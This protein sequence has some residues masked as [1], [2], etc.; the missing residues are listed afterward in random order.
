M[1]Q[2]QA[3]SRIGTVLQDRYIIEGVLGKGG[4]STVYLVRDQQTSAKLDTPDTPDAPNTPN[5]S[6]MLEKQDAPQHDLFALKML[7]NQE[8]QE[9]NRFMFECTVLER[10][11]HPALPHVHG[12]FEDDHAYLLMDYI[13]GPNLETLRQRQ[14]TKRFSFA[15]VLTLLTPIVEA[16]TY[17]H[18]QQPPI[19]HRDIKP[20]NI[21]VPQLMDKAV[22][23]D[24][25]IAKEFEPDATT[26][27]IRHCSPGYGAP[28]QY[29]SMGT[30]QR[31]D[32]YGLAATCY[33]LLTGRVP[34]DALQR[35]TSLAS[36]GVDP[37]L[38]LKELAPTLPANAADAIQRAMSIGSDDRFATVQEFWQALHNAETTESKETSSEN[39]RASSWRIIQTPAHSLTRLSRPRRA[40]VWLSA[41]FALL[42]IVGVGSG[43]LTYNLSQHRTQ[44]TASSLSGPHL[45]QKPMPS[46]DST[47][48]VYSNLALSYQGTI[49]NML[50][51]VTTPL[52]LVQIQQRDQNIHGTFQALKGSGTF[53]GVLDTSK[54]I[55]FTVSGTSSM[56]LFF[57]GSVRADGNLVGSYCALDSGGQCAGE[58]GIWSVGP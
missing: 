29:S 16:I 21:I 19:V 26:T 20:S 25:G 30:D 5:T 32:V 17:L 11:D 43:F 13:A 53:S 41:V 18:Q 49:H 38:S 35:A 40:A 56:P 7:T 37:L 47:I 45:K 4:F 39:M 46:T 22:L 15:K 1:E 6:T 9:K 55:F 36:R 8:Q 48:G 12:V 34:I 10:L 28:E 57:Q 33:T 54:H 42:L 50:T 58:Y 2:T 24:F 31:A 51:N 14:T 23:V 27:A 52:S 44:S 3:H